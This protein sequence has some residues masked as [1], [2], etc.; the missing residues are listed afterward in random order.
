M[1][2]A[3]AIVVSVPEDAES[4]DLVVTDAEVTQRLSLLDG[5]PGDGNLRVLARTN[6]FQAVGAAHRVA[7][8]GRDAGGSAS[9]TGT[10]TV[11]D[12]SLQ[13]FL[14]DDP[15]KRASRPDAALL[16]LHVTY[17]WSGVEP[18]HAGLT[19]QAFT[20]ALPDGRV[21]EATNLAADPDSEAIVA[22]EVPASFTT[23]TLHIGGVDRQPSGLAIDFGANVYDTEISIPAG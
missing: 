6:R 23:G 21:V 4:A 5:T 3:S 17:A 12:V 19:P 9:I 14:A 20:L 13:W 22:L 18:A 15:S 7:A 10:I 11:E 16:V 2:G 8:T 1:D